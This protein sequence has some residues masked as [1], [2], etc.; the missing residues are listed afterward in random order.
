MTTPTKDF[1]EILGVKESA[2]QEE[3]KK[4]YRKL[5]KK[6][7]PDANPGNPKG[8][9]RFKEIGEAYSVLSNEEKR[10]HYNQMKRLGAFGFGPGAGKGPFS[11]GGPGPGYGGTRPGES[12]S[13]E[14]LSGFGGGISDL[15]STIFDRGK[16]ETGKG[17]SGPSKGR[18]VEYVV[19][20]AFET[21]VRGGRISIN[22]PITEEC[23]TCAGS[24]AA[25]GTSSKTCSE[26]RGTGTVS[27]GQGGFAV[28]R[29][30]PACV[31][32]GTIPESPCKPC[33]GT[34]TV[35]QSRK[36]QV[37]VPKG[38]EGGSKVRLTGQGERGSLGGTPGDL[39]ITFKVKPH[40]FFRRDG[41]DLEVTVPINIAQAS[42]GSK[43]RVRT[44]DGKKVV[45]SIPPATQPGT[46]FRVRG[47][48]VEKGG[49][50]GD[51]YV[52]VKLEVPEKLTPEGQRLMEA[53]ATDA[54]LKY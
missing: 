51:L 17:R 28:K 48:G 16:K 19:E 40:R 35:R 26:C 50:V 23:A 20:V 43:I 13:F 14:D 25:P 31:G 27:F 1:Y 46:R 21:S 6:H 9:E 12:F 8:S 7:H 39:V 49:R 42:L 41:L 30:C 10:K 29:P 5:A 33:D 52:E 11:R 15:F 32:R 36:I 38:V 34:G 44:M 3:I 53:L 18:S 4:A 47:Q 2:S 45:L 22:V 54:E 24:G 37:T